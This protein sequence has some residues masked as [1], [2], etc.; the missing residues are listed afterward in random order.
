V[1]EIKN[2]IKY[3]TVRNSNFPTRSSKY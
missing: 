3:L 2:S 1:F